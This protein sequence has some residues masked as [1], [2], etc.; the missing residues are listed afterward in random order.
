MKSQ[1]GDMNVSHS[2]FGKCKILYTKIS[3][4]KHNSKE[5]QRIR[6]KYT[7]RTKLNSNR[8]QDM[9]DFNSSISLP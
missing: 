3:Q 1:N 4:R 2:L 6:G 9:G 5:K 8:H 7:I